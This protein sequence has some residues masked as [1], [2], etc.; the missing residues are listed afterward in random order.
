MPREACEGEG[1]G[2][3]EGRAGH[4][5]EQRGS[6]GLDPQHVGKRKSQ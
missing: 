4:E 6:G 1:E 2:L 3:E 5:A